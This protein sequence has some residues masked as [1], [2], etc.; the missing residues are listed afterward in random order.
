MERGRRAPGRIRA[1]H[2]SWCRVA[3]GPAAARSVTTCQLTGQFAQIAIGDDKSRRDRRQTLTA[4]VS[5]RPSVV[6][7]D[8]DTGAPSRS[9][10]T[11]CA[12]AR[13]GPTLGRLPITW[14]AALPTR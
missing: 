6:V 12:S 2:R 1:R 4:P 14:T 13:R 8:T 7:A 9:D 11:S 3:A 5:P 10:S